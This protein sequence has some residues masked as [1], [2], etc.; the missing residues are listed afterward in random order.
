MALK[1]VRETMRDESVKSGVGHDD[2]D[3]GVGRRIFGRN[4]PSVAQQAHLVDE[5]F[6]ERGR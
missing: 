4:G 1:K 6:E 5:A 3:R 2:D